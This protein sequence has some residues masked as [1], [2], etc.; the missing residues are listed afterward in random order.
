MGITLHLALEVVAA[1][2]WWALA[3]SLQHK[4][5]LEQPHRQP[6]PHGHLAEVDEDGHQRNGVGRE[7]LQVEPIILQQ[8]EE[9]GRQRRHQPSHG[10]HRKEDKVP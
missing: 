4:E 1:D 8:R 5:V 10:V 6:H 9:E 7:V 2:E 3:R